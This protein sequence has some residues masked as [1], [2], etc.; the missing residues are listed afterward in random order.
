MRFCSCPYCGGNAKV[1]F[2]DDNGKMRW[3]CCNCDFIGDLDELVRE[4]ME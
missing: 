3:V 4:A 1:I 2:R